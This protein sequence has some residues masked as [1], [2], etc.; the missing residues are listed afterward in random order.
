[1]KNTIATQIGSLDT[2]LSPLKLAAHAVAWGK[3]GEGTDRQ[4]LPLRSFIEPIDIKEELRKDTIETHRVMDEYFDKAEAHQRHMNALY[5]AIIG[6]NLA[7]SDFTH[8]GKHSIK[9]EVLQDAGVIMAI[10]TCDTIPEW[11][12]ENDLIYISTFLNLSL[13]GAHDKFR[14]DAY[15]SL[16]NFINK[17]ASFDSKLK[18]DPEPELENQIPPQGQASDF[19]HLAQKAQD[20]MSMAQKRERLMALHANLNAEGL[21][22]MGAKN[23]DYSGGTGDP[24]ANFRAA[25][26]LGIPAE[27]GIL[28]RCMDKIQ[29]I[30]SFVTNGKLQVKSESVRDAIVDVRN[31][32]VLLAGMI[33]DREWEGK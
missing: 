24:Y 26:V 3:L 9:F 25:E 7:Q 19:I 30:R 17:E 14:C 13:R 5:S 18:E 4:P 20:S 15:H 11:R 21:A 16:K 23:A 6:L 1:M 33:E 22:I 10:A 27:L 31:C 29:R 12:V 8:H 32:M 2:P 28:M